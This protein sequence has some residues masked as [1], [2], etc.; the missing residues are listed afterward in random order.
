MGVCTDVASSANRQTLICTQIIV[1]SINRSFQFRKISGKLTQDSRLKMR[2]SIFFVT[3]GQRQPIRELD[4][5]PDF[6]ILFLILYD[7]LS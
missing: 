6:F 5:P 2:F 7:I 1:C 4:F 3:W